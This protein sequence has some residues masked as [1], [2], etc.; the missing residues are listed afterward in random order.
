MS[1]PQILARM[2]VKRVN[3][4]IQVYGASYGDSEL[5]LVMDLADRWLMAYI[6]MAYIVIYIVMA[7]CSYGLADRWLMAFIV[8]V[9]VVMAHVVMA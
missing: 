2:S 9:Y 1:P 7:V 3:S 4:C 5:V 8:M 6:G